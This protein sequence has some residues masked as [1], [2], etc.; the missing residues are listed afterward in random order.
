MGFFSKILNGLKKTKNSISGALSKIFKRGLDEEFY[1]DLENILISADVGA[2]C[3]M[4][5]VDELRERPSTT[6]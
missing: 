6:S 3:A 1:E 5:I 4:E 2:P